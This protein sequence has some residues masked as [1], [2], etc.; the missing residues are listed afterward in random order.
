MELHLS[1]KTVSSHMEAIYDRLNLR[2]LP[3]GLN[4]HSLLA[5]L[6]LLHNLQMDQEKDGNG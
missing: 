6:Q 5:K 3:V 4:P 2:S 1:P